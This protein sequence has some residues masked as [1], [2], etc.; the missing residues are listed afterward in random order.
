VLLARHDE[1]IGTR[2]LADAVEALDY[3]EAIIPPFATVLRV[4]QVRMSQAGAEA[5]RGRTA[6]AIAWL[7]RDAA[8]HRR[9]L[10]EAGS[11]LTKTIAVRT[12]SRDF[13]LA[14]QLARAGL[15]LTFGGR[16]DRVAFA[17]Y[18]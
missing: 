10:E 17:A 8:F 13:L 15:P 6:E 3:H 7:G 14:G 16:G 5:S 4:Q 1:L 9:W 12:L 11:I 18:P 2:G